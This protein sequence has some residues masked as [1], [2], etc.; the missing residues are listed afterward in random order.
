[1]YGTHIDIDDRKPAEQA[2]RRSEAY[3]T[4]VQRLSHT[5]NFAW[6]T[7][8]GAIHWSEESFRIM[9]FDRTVKPTIELMLQRVHPDDVALVRR[10]IDLASRGGQN[11]ST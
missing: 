9:G 8:S 10:A 6:A 4:E 11:I 7:V 1:M 5:G 2:L 3:L